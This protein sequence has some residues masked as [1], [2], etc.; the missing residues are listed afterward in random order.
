MMKLLICLVAVLLLS[1]SV[2]AQ[3]VESVL[4]KVENADDV[5]RVRVGSLLMSMGR[6]AARM[7]GNPI[8]HI[9]GVNVYDLSESSAQFR[10]N[11]IN[12][13]R[14]LRDGDGFET[15]MH[16]RDS[17][18]DVRI[19]ARTDRNNTIRE[20]V[21]FIISDDSPAVIRI[22]GRIGESEIADLIS[23]HAR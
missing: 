4:R 12:E 21:F 18:N 20:L 5:T 11:L 22:S 23:Q 7:S 2:H 10:R 13:L 3:S 14:Q 16:V 9:T 19:M 17:D 8:P 15:L 6:T 1:T